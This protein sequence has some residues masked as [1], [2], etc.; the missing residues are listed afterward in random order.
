M[1]ATSSG[2]YLGRDGILDSTPVN[3]GV[4]GNVALAI[5]CKI[6]SITPTGV[7]SKPTELRNV[8]GAINAGSLS[9]FTV[10]LV[11]YSAQ[12]TI[13][14]F[15]AHIS[16]SATPTLGSF[17]TN[18]TI[19]SYDNLNGRLSI[20]TT[21]LDITTNQYLTVFVRSGT[22]S[23]Y[24]ETTLTI[25][26]T[27]VVPSWS[28]FILWN[29]TSTKT[30]GWEQQ[31]ALFART[32]T[33]RLSSAYTVFMRA[34]VDDTMYTTLIGSPWNS[35]TGSAGDMVLKSQFFG[36]QTDTSLIGI[37]PKIPIAGCWIAPVTYTDIGGV[38]Q[39]ISTVSADNG[40][41]YHQRWGG[42]S[43]PGF[44]RWGYK[45]SVTARAVG[46]CQRY[47]NAAN[48][49]TLSGFSS[50]SFTSGTSLCSFSNGQLAAE[51][52]GREYRW[53]Q[54]SS[55]DQYTH[56]ELRSSNHINTAACFPPILS[57]TYSGSGA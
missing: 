9:T 55:P 18:C 16:P 45:F 44:I 31:S 10:D 50:N 11:N 37:N 2:K 57:A 15:T 41:P 28:S 34:V 42:L 8:Q 40:T 6:F 51:Y 23:G 48:T 3:S 39:G 1:V 27:I 54:I 13:L 17:V 14:D 43:I 12:N 30:P 32:S 35:S 22:G 47:V 38:Q 21:L 4:V 49:W 20:N 46:M 36:D 7:Y 19:I 5:G 56:Y 25:G 52:E 26:L 53:I 29:G 24:L 33:H